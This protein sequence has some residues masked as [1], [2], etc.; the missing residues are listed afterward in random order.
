MNEEVIP[1]LR[2]DDAAAAAGWYRRLGFVTLWEHR[3]EPGFPA[4]VEVARGQVRL[5]LSEHTGDAR[6]DTLVYLRVADVDAVAAEFGVPVRSAPWA[7]ETE[8]RDPD[9]NRL[10]V[11]TPTPAGG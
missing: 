5:F 9:G 2:V 3:F 7:R 4:F 6:P 10:R 11:G 8:L 1:I